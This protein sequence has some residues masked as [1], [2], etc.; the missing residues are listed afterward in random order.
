MDFKGRQFN[1]SKSARKI[2]HAYYELENL[3]VKVKILCS[4]KGEPPMI[5]HQSSRS[6]LSFLH[7][8]LSMARN[9]VV[10]FR[11]A[12]G[13]VSATPFRRGRVEVDV[14]KPSESDSGDEIQAVLL[15]T[16]A[17]NIDSNS[18]SSS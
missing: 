2:I 4:S 14:L 6:K 18:V 15:E 13:Q 9:F 12:L 17:S 5:S 16:I 10:G 7:N 8:P 11:G 3:E 1:V